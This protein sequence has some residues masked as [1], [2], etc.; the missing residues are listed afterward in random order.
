MQRQMAETPTLRT[1]KRVLFAVVAPLQRFFQT[2]A[3]SGIMLIASAAVALAWANS[4]WEA[5]YHDLFHVSVEMRVGGRGLSWPLHS[6]VNEALMSVFFLLAGMEIKREVVAG[7]LRTLRRAALPLIAAA[8]GMVLPAVIYFAINRNGPGGAGWGI[9]MATDIAFALGCM[10][11]VRRRVPN[12]L[13]VFLTALAIFDDLGAILIVALF[14]GGAI[15]WSAMAVAALLVAA[16]FGLGRARVQRT[17]PYLVLG[18]GLWAALLRAGL[19]PTLAGVVLGLAL[20][21]VGRKG[22]AD[23]IEDLYA[24]LDALRQMSRKD[25][26]NVEAGALTSLE[27]HIESVQSPLDRLTHS[28][29]HVVAFGIVPLFALSNAGLSLGDLTLGHGEGSVMAGALV[30]L[31][32]GKTAGVFGATWV[33]VRAGLAPRPSH[34]SWAQVLAASVLAG[35]GF[36]MS[37]FIASLAF[38]DDALNDAAKAGVF[39]ASLVCSVA[40]VVLLRVFGKPVTKAEAPHEAPVVVDL[41]RFAHGY[42]VEPWDVQGELVGKTLEDADLRR[43][44]GIT[45]I[46]VW[47]RSAQEKSRRLEAVKPTDVLLAGDTLLLVGEE[48][49]VDNFLKPTSSDC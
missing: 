40:G 49:R 29:H 47:R 14:Y 23:A 39:G 28:L 18:V 8:G 36:T 32:A 22:T 17:W 44:H 35:V 7:E 13:I 42:R 12:S 11:L 15:S 33:A 41:L 37:I 48:A 26:A 43:T 27:E 45:V 9:P 19:H 20:P 6:W 24:A 16:L 34:A 31:V 5:S 21:V 2:Q 10:S 38:A 1:A 30:G 3:A 46:G 25:G 4:P